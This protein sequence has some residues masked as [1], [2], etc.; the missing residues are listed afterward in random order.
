MISTRAVELV[1][2]LFDKT[3]DNMLVWESSAED[4]VYQLSYPNFSIQIFERLTQ[5][6]SDIVIHVFNENADLV[7]EITDVD[8]QDTGEFE[9]AYHI[10]SD[11][12][13]KARAQ[14][15]GTE[16]VIDDILKQL[17]S[18]KP[19]PPTKKGDEIPF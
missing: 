4:G 5:Q 3:M 14:A 8:I 2:T 6:G 16:K 1:R 13:K 15:L 19:P 18:P 9:S 17:K 12:Y 11:I 10:M 7:D